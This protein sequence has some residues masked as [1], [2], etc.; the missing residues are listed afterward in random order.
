V[1]IPK[2]TGDEG[3]YKF[4]FLNHILRKFEK[5]QEK[6]TPIAFSFPSTPNIVQD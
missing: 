6:R 5:I 2:K 4:F 3:Y 1:L